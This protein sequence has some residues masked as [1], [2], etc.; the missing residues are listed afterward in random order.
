MLLSD[1]FAVE[2]LYYLC[3]MSYLGLQFEDNFVSN[4]P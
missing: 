1:L 2:K 3:S 4:N